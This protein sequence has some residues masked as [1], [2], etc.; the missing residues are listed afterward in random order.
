MISGT[1]TGQFGLSTMFGQALNEA[2]WFAA[3]FML[4]RL[5]IRFGLVPF[6]SSSRHKIPK[7]KVRS[8]A[9]KVI[10]AD[11][12]AGNHAAVLQLW[13][14]ERDSDVTLPVDALQAVAQALA[15]LEPASLGTE[16][17]TYLS[18]HQAL[19]KSATL[20]A[21]LGCIDKPDLAEQLSQALA[22]LM[23]SKARDQVVGSF[24]ASGNVEKVRELLRSSEDQLHSGASAIR[25]FLKGGHMSLALNQILEM[26]QA[27][28]QVPTNALVAFVR[29]TPSSSLPLPEA[30]VALKNIPLPIEAAAA[31]MSECLARED[32]DT[33]LMLEERLR[34]ENA[35]LTY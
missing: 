26:Q 4:F 9:G 35:A 27:G 11:S 24:A 18:R 22:N 5:L 23:D 21:L 28:L 33:A 13:R 6:W 32:T 30:I 14:Q 34:N 1:E 12:D 16:M 2:L 15:I 7:V 19:Q 29:A 3:G 17:A 10:C 8:R 25:G 20:H 31:A